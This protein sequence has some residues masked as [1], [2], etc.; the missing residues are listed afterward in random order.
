VARDSELAPAKINLTLHVTGQRSDGFHTLE[1]L[2]V[3][4]DAA[5]RVEATMADDDTLTLSGCFADGLSI[6]EDN[7]VLKAITAFRSR[8]PDSLPQRFH[9]EL[10]KSLPVAAGIGGG[11]ADAAA[12]LRLL[13]RLSQRDFS[14]AELAPIAAGL[15]A[16]VPACLIGAPMIV[17]GIGDNIRPISQFPHCHLVLVNP[18]VPIATPTVFM[19]LQHKKNGGLPDFSDAIGDL[20]SMI[21]WLKGTRNDLV[22]PATAIAPVVGDIIRDLDEIENCLFARMSGSG[23]TIFGL[24]ADQR[25][26][27]DAI[28]QMS[29]ARPD[30]WIVSAG[31]F[32]PN[33]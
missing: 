3:F 8:W 16:D 27:K 21:G 1:S 22:A 20:D 24:F 12:T 4:A 15:G 17:S 11:S 10:T 28:K 19:G 25:H 30:C 26:A 18:L 9:F 29:A 33:Q 7:L 6:D 13:A 2:I 31:L 14:L 5:D 23:A 32:M